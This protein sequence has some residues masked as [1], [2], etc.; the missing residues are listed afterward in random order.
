M[1]CKDFLTSA[2]ASLKAFDQTNQQVDLRN[3]ISRSYYAAFHTAGEAAD[4][5]SLPKALDTSLGSH[6]EVIERFRLSRDAQLKT[7]GD[8]LQLAKRERHIADYQL[9]YLLTNF[10]ASAHVERCS[11]IHG[12]LALKCNASISPTEV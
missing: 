1:D 12:R 10:D 11:K 5:L 2:K 3:A 9:Q 6:E 8:M 4:L 7:E